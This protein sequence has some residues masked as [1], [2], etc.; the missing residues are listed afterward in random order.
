MSNLRIKFVR[1]EEVKYI[2]H[3]DL[4]NVFERALRRAKIPIYYS[5][6]FN[7]HPHLVFGLPLS[8]GTTSETEYADFELA[9]YM[10]P[11]LFTNKLNNELPIGLKIIDTREKHSKSN[12]MASISM[13]SY[14]IS[15]ITEAKTGNDLIQKRI[16]VFMSKSSIIVKKQTKNS[17][18]DIDIK[19][20]IHKLDIVEIDDKHYNELP[21]SDSECESVLYLNMLLSAGSVANLK[22]ELLVTALSEE[23]DLKVKFIRVH[24]TGLFINVEGRISDPMD[25]SVLNSL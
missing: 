4:M 21:K 13:A 5:Q 22:P 24:R 11:S 20:M 8:V 1:G 16:E 23:L 25:I 19:P 17:L 15:V 6:G 3:L 12:I 7:P 10:E 2:S 18:K 9:E 14:K